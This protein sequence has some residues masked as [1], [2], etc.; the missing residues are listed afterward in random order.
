MHLWART[1]KTLTRHLRGR[2]D[3]A[4]GVFAEEI[5]PFLR[6]RRLAA[7]IEAGPPTR[8]IIDEDLPGEYVAGLVEGLL[9]LTGAQPHIEVAGPTLVV[10]YRMHRA[11]QIARIIHQAAQLRIPLLATSGAAASVGLAIAGAPWLLWAV[12]L[13]GTMAA[14]SGANAIHDLWRPGPRNVLGAP[15]LGKRWLWFQ[16]AGSYTLAA[17]AL[18]WLIQ[19]RPGVL[20]F[21]A[22][23]VAFGAAY[24]QLRDLGWGPAIAA[25]TH[26]PLIVWGAAYAA[27]A[28]WGPQWAFALPTGL[29]AAAMIYL[30]DLIDRPLDEASGNRTLVVRLTPRARLLGHQA[31]MAAGAGLSLGLGAAMGRWSLA[32]G[33]ALLATWTMVEVRQN[34][35]DPRGM[36]TARALG[37]ATFLMAAAHLTLELP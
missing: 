20:A 15:R 18:S 7:R 14:Q 21:A 10:R 27:G 16:A 34:A 17:A 13:S 11:D 8:L 6:G 9:E 23:G 29:F 1:F 19:S 37:F 31:L 26:G 36:T 5:Y 25:V 4:L 33:T 12:I 28:S 30:D 24:S 3:R 35:D 22:A 32:M 2:P